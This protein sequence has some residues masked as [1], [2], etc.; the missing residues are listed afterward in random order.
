M[1]SF[2]SS[3]QVIFTDSFFQQ[4][5]LL[6][7]LSAYIL[8][9]LGVALALV[10]FTLRLRRSNEHKALFWQ[11]LEARW[12]PLL[13]KIIAREAWP[14]H[15]HQQVQAHEAFY[16]VDFLTRY[17]EKLTGHA[18]DTLSQLAEP[19]LGGIAERARTGDT[20]QRARAI[21]TLSA[22]APQKYA[23]VILQ[24]L[25]DSAPLVVMLTARALAEQHQARYLT[26]IL[27]KIALFETWSQ[28]YLVNLLVELG[29]ES[30]EALRQ[31]LNQTERP[32]WI[33]VVIVK[34]LTELH[35]WQALP[36]AEVLLR[37]EPD[38][39]LQA[40]ALYLL[41]HLGHA[42]HAEIVRQKCHSADFVIRLHAIKAMVRL[43]GPEDEALLRAQLADPSQWVALH[44]IEA[45]KSAR[46][47]GVLQE[48][49]QSEDPRR[50]MA[51][52]A[53]VDAPAAFRQ[54]IQGQA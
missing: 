4:P 42:Q 13:M 5:W 18:H 46:L 9:L 43:A 33:R 11:A 31:E 52:Q 47:F 17:A 8:V 15:L 35:D 25:D 41:G 28:N 54:V 53:L 16:F 44:A 36:L 7:A 50:E 45:L 22:L 14:E 49:A 1:S 23:E 37:Q 30:P 32:A 51:Q 24:G 3:I 19:Y 6:L 29:R 27:D 21:L 38:R 12:E 26:V 40:A 20:E 34:A 2:L 48:L 39:D 10:I